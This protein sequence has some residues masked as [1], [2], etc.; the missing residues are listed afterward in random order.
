MLCTSLAVAQQSACAARRRAR[1]PGTLTVPDP[2]KC[3]VR[4]ESQKKARAVG[5]RL[6]LTGPDLGPRPARCR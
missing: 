4:C 3:Q 5:C 1:T 2:E 6:T